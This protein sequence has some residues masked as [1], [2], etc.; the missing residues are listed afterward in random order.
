V[1]KQRRQIDAPRNLQKE[2]L[3]KIVTTTVSKEGFALKS[4]FAAFKE[5][6][7]KAK[8]EGVQLLCLPGGYFCVKSETEFKHAE[9]RIVQEAKSAGIAVA[10]GIDR[11][12]GAKSKKKKGTPIPYTEP[13]FVVTWSPQQRKQRWRQRSS[14]RKDQRFISDKD[15]ARSQ[16]LSVSGRKVEILACGEIFNKRIRNNIIDR[17]PF[18][19]IDL[20]HEGKGFRVDPSLKLL[21][22]NDMHTFCCTHANVKD[23]TKRAFAPGGDKKSISATDFCTTGEP[24]IEMKLWKI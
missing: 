10:V 8:N 18:A 13:S 15:C 19:L 22:R 24:R 7:E 17:H 2:N 23:A 5:A 9:S 14:T 20:G 16:T 21:A 1:V 6:L 3:M 4:R 11:F 12:Q